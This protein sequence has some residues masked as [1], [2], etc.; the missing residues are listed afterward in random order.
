MILFSISRLCLQT[1]TTKMRDQVKAIYLTYAAD[2]TIMSRHTSVPSHSFVKLLYGMFSSTRFSGLKFP[3]K[4]SRGYL[5]QWSS[6]SSSGKERR[7][8]GRETL[9]SF[10]EVG[11]WSFSNLSLSISSNT[12]ELSFSF[13]PDAF[14]NMPS[15]ISVP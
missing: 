8:S 4:D 11:Q 9:Q 7:P 6:R 10:S 1:R 13:K 14:R 12:L 15:I 3:G 5:S 2:C